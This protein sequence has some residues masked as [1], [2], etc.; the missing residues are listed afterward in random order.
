MQITV[1]HWSTHF[2]IDILVIA[3]NKGKKRFYDCHCLLESLN[4]FPQ[5]L[6]RFQNNSLCLSHIMFESFKLDK[7]CKAPVNV[8]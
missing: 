4:Y 8:H 5:K 2:I 3:H 7:T 1:P 6:S